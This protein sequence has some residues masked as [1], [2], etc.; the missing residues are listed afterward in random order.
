MSISRF[1]R[2][3]IDNDSYTVISKKAFCE[4]VDLSQ[5]VDKCLEFAYKMTFG[6]V[7]EHRDHRSGGS[8]HRDMLEKFQ[9]TIQGKLAEY[10]LF[11][12]I[13]SH[14]FAIEEPDLNAYGEGIWDDV[15]LTVNEKRISVKSAAFFS[16]LLLLEKA[17]WDENGF[18][19]PSEQ[20][21]TNC[22]DFFVLCRIRPDAKTVF[23][24]QNDT[25]N[26]SLEN[27]LSLAKAEHWV[28]DIPGYI[29]R[30]NLMKLIKEKYIIPK[31]ALLNG[32]LAMDADNYYCQAGDLW[33]AGLFIR[34]LRGDIPEEYLKQANR[35]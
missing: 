1:K 13:K 30:A 2:L 6:K 19:I 29:T 32:K 23:V 18:Y 10:G 11:D 25:K 33:D 22:Y 9:N 17:D 12:Y 24:P 20:D 34:I 21:E 31:G 7:G 26:Y 4:M 5:Y 35:K 3:L 28:M 8:E 15:D 14:Y 27:L 16:Q